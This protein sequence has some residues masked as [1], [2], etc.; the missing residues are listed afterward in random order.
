MKKS[1]LLGLCAAFLSCGY[2]FSVP[3]FQPPN[4]GNSEFYPMMQYQ[5]EKQETL[6]FINDSENYK[7]KRKKKDSKNVAKE[8]SNFNPNY[9]PN[10][11]IN[12]VHYTQPAMQF[13]TD[14]NGNI[15]IQSVPSK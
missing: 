14:E 9:T 15:K 6:D 4:G 11:G 12:N 5:M 8:S 10:Y 7:E 1:L 2:A 3:A 13:T